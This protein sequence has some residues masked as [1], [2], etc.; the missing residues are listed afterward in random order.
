MNTPC[1]KSLTSHGDRPDRTLSR[2]PH[3]TRTSRP[4]PRPSPGRS[5]MKTNGMISQLKGWNI[6]GSAGNRVMRAPT[7]CILHSCHPV[8][9]SDAVAWFNSPTEVGEGS[10]AS[11]FESASGNP[12]ASRCDLDAFYHVYE[13]LDYIYV[14]LQA[15]AKL[16]IYIT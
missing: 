10:C 2:P 5:R 6:S 7:P 16:Y 9:S 1:Y 8:G 12:W 15:R 4:T 13:R 11:M 14:G 3:S